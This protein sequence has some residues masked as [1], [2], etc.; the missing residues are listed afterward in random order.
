MSSKTRIREINIVEETGTFSAFFKKMSGEEAEYNL[1]GISALRRLLSNEKAKLL[2]TIKIKKPNSLYQLAK[3]LNRDF[4]SVCED[5][6]LLERFGFIDMISERTGKRI[7]LR[8]ILA[9]D[10]VQINLK[11]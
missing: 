6:K 11:I 10:S 3:L 1:D 8:P 4:K 7:R 9:V 2:S 5:I